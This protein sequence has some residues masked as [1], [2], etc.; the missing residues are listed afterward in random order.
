MGET[1]AELIRIATDHPSLLSAESQVADICVFDSIGIPPLLWSPEYAWEQLTRNNNGDTEVD[2][3]NKVEAFIYDL[4]RQQEPLLSKRN[5]RYYTFIITKQALPDQHGVANREL[6]GR[7]LSLETSIW[8]LASC[9]CALFNVTQSA[10]TIHS[11]G[12]GGNNNDPVVAIAVENANPRIASPQEATTYEELF[13]HM[14]KHA[15][16][17][18]V[19]LQPVLLHL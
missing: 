15:Q 11:G 6:L 1:T 4:H 3:A 7:L 14:Q 16:P 9:C 13:N 10:F 18:C 12:L 8:V 19:E 2:D 5:D 17:L